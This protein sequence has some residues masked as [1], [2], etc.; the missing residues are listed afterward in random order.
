MSARPR[1]C[2]AAKVIQ[3]VETMSLIGAGTQDDPCRDIY[4]YWALDGTLLAARDTLNELQ[5]GAQEH[6]GERADPRDH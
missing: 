2:D 4:Q 3:V 5:K 1:G 6:D